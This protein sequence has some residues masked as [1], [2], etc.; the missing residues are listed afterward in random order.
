MRWMI[1]ST[2]RFP[3]TS[4]SAGARKLPPSEP[5]LPL[6]SPSC[7][8]PS[9]PFLLHVRKVTRDPPKSPPPF[10][11]VCRH[12]CP[13]LDPISS[14]VAERGNRLSRRAQ[15]R[16]SRRRPGAKARRGARKDKWSLRG[17][18]SP[19]QRPS[20]P[21]QRPSG[22]CVGRSPPRRTPLCGLNF[23]VFYAHSRASLRSVRALATYVVS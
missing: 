6:P 1:S 19:C 17:A 9:A 5:S 16:S 10:T 4:A 18:K 23:G 11:S 3:R 2:R 13:L 12:L 15:A 14:C 21:C 20:G 22:P 8:I 7:L